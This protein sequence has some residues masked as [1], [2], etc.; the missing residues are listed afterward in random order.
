MKLKAEVKPV[1]TCKKTCHAG[2]LGKD[3]CFADVTWLIT[4]MAASLKPSNCLSHHLTSSIQRPVSRC[5]KYM[6]CISSLQS[7]WPVPGPLRL[8]LCSLAPSS[9]QD[10]GHGPG[11]GRRQQRAGHVR[12]GRAQDKEGDV[13]HGRPAVQGVSHQADGHA[14]E[15]QPQ[16]PALYHPQPREEGRK[17]EATGLNRPVAV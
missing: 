2:A 15:H 3:W 6:R 1:Q 14:E 5:D 4:N 7:P 10:R 12:R 17:R 13:P 8:T 16:L 11:V 9:G